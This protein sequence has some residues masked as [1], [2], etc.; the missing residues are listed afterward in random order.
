MRLHHELSPYSLVPSDNNGL[1]DVFLQADLSRGANL[2][3]KSRRWACRQCGLKYSGAS[4]RK[5][6]NCRKNQPEL[7][8][9]TPETPEMMTL[10]SL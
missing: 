6:K 3:Q 8:A 10:R 9:T 5:K 7:E 1:Q 4:A 2:E